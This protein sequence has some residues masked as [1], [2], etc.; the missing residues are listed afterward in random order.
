M[1]VLEVDQTLGDLIMLNADQSGIL[2]RAY[3]AVAIDRYSGMPVGIHFG[4][5]PPSAQSLVSLVRNILLPKSYVQ[6]R[7]PDITQVWE[8]SGP[9][10][11][12]VFDQALENKGWAAK[13]LC[14]SHHIDVKFN[15]A[16][17][18]YQK[19]DVERFWGTLATDFFHRL[20]G[21]TFSNIRER[22]DYDPAKRACLTYDEVERLIH[23]WLVEVYA[24]QP[25]NPNDSRTRREIWLEGQSKRPF[26]PPR[27]V[28]DY[29]IF[30]FGRARPKLNGRGVRIHNEFYISRD[31]ENLRKRF[32]DINVE[33]RYDPA[34]MSTVEVYNK[35]TDSWI[36]A[37]NVDPTHR[38]CSLYQ[39]RLEHKFLRGKG[40]QAQRALRG[41]RQKLA[42]QEEIDRVEKVS[43]KKMSKL[44]RVDARAQRIGIDPHSHQSD[45][46]KK[47]SLPVVRPRAAFQRKDIDLSEFDT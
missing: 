2:G 31:L 20:P 8:T 1:E 30:M 32:G 41:A 23:Y 25:R 39:L 17:R 18:A 15:G 43:R 35:Q 29:G 16:R 13:K 4:F 40:S 42:F 44:R 9:P 45:R 36:V 19:G 33:V 10:K 7:W 47:G 24:N 38:G 22:G 37:H 3:C 34:N 26:I 6:H 11:E 27:P 28:T 14:E 21:T 46:E 12:L 5:E